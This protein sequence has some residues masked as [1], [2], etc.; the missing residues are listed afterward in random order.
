MRAVRS[1]LLIRVTTRSPDTRPTVPAK[2][3]GRSP[4]CSV[5]RSMAQPCSRPT[6]ATCGRTRP[7]VA[8]RHRG[9][10]PD[11]EGSRSM[12]PAMSGCRHRWGSCASTPP[13]VR[14]R[15]IGGGDL[16]DPFGIALG[17]GELYVA[18][19]GDGKVKRFSTATALLRQW[20][21]YPGLGVED[22]PTGVAADAAGNVYVTN[23][24]Q[25][26]IQKFDVDGNFIQ[27]F[28][29][30]GSLLG[31]LQ[32]PGAVAVS[33]YNG[34]LYVADT[35]NNRIQRFT[36]DGTAV[37]G[38]AASV[39]SLERSDD[40]AGCRNRSRKRQRI[41]IRH[42]KQ[43]IA[44]VRP[45]RQ[46]HHL[47]GGVRNQHGTVQAATRPHCVWGIC[48]G[49]RHGQ[50]SHPEV[51]D[52]GCIPDCLGN[53][54]GFRRPVEVS[55][56][57]CAGCGEHGVGRRPRQQSDST[58]H[59]NGLPAV[60]ARLK[61]ARH[62]PVRRAVR[63]RDRQRRQRPR[64]GHE[65]PPC[66][67]VHRQQRARCDICQRSGHRHEV[68]C[69]QLHLPANEPGS[70]FE[71][72][73]DSGTWNACGSSVTYSSLAESPHSLAVRATD[74]LGHLGNPTSYAWVIDVTPRRYR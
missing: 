47:L 60:Q 17:A 6:A 23:K 62:R 49:G 44:E 65:Q 48:L 69:R 8:A 50:Q 54:G 70:T 42:R 16:S 56:R 31:K 4:V 71:C 45:A 38:G 29:G 10:R 46:L 12:A 43:P 28:G 21:T 61:R 64:R 39:H 32:N 11:L 53:H 34:M 66:A 15:A 33:P 9:A 73:L 30:Y 1:S 74:S 52:R 55:I 35:T 3:S 24:T 51:L 72:K 14:R 57:R 22:L 25:D 7:P 59:D 13:Q 41:R 36:T 68:V 58:V 20:G 37:R 26:V 40:P 67:G 2:R 19:N 27:Q 18:D 63:D 5:W